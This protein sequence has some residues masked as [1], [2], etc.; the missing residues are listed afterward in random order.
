MKTPRANRNEVRE[1]S[2]TVPMSKDEK[3]KIQKR[4]DEMGVTMSAF[5]RFAVNDFLKKYE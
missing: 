1:M 2:L 4:A 3:E 5:V